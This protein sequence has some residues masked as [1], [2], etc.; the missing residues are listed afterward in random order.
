MGGQRRFSSPC[1]PQCF[2]RKH[3]NRCAVFTISAFSTEAGTERV[4]DTTFG[5]NL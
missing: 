2:L 5:R 1:M 3:P 4:V